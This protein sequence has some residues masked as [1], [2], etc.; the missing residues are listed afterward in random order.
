MIL[1]GTKKE[2]IDTMDKNT[3]FNQAVLH[4]PRWMDIRKRKETSEGGKF[5]K[6]IIGEIDD[7]QKEE[8]NYRGEFFLANYVG[9]EDKIID[10]L[11]Q[12]KVGD[13]HEGAVHLLDPDVSVVTT[14]E[15][16]YKGEETIA[17]HKEGMVF[18]KF[19]PNSKGEIKYTVNG[20]T[21]GAKVEKI[22][23]W[24]VFDEFALFS[25]LERYENEENKTLLKR[26]LM[27]FKRRPSSTAEGIANAIANGLI[28]Y[29]EI[30]PS[31]VEVS[32]AT[33]EDLLFADEEYGTVLERL[34]QVNRDVFRTKRWDESKWEHRFKELSYAP[35][36]WDCHP[37]L[38]QDGVGGDDA[39]KAS[40]LSDL[41]TGEGTNASIDLYEKSEAKVN[42]YIR[43]RRVE[44]DINLKLEKYSNV[45]VPKD[46]EYK[47]I[48]TPAVELGKDDIYIDCHQTS[49][50]EKD[51]YV[52]DLVLNKE[53]ISSSTVERGALKT[54]KKYKLRF[55]PKDTYGTMEIS[56]AVVSKNDGA[57]SLLGAKGAFGFGQDSIFKNMNVKLHTKDLADLSRFEN[58]KNSEKGLTLENAAKDGFGVIN[59]SDYSGQSVHIE[60]DIQDT[61]ITHNPSFVSLTGDLEISSENKI[62]STGQEGKIVIKTKCN[63]ISYGMSSGN[64]IVTK[65]INGVQSA[66]E[67]WFQPKSEKLEFTE[68]KD[69]T[70]VIQ[71]M[72]NS[73]PLVVENIRYARYTVDFEL[74]NRRLIRTPMGSVIPDLKGERENLIVTLRTHTGLS[75][76]VKFIHIGGNL[77]NAQYETDIFEGSAGA[78]LDVESNCEVVLETYDAN[79]V[80]EKTDRP[81]IS[82]DRYENKTSA[83]VYVEVDV[84]K[85][86]N[87][88]RTKPA[89]E[90]FSHQGRFSSWIKLL[91]GESLDTIRIDG[92]VKV[93]L[94]RVRINN[95]LKNN[96][97][98]EI[99]GAGK[100]KGF[101]VKRNE[102][103]EL[104]QI[105]RTDLATKADAYTIH[106]LPVGMRGAF[107]VDEKN[108]IESIGTSHNLSFE[109]F[110]IITT[111]Q[112]HIAYN[113]VRIIKQEISGVEIV[114]MFTPLVEPNKNMV[115]TIE[116]GDPNSKVTFMHEKSLQDWSLGKKPIHVFAGIN[117]TLNTNYQ[118]EML[119]LNKK[120]VLGNNMDLEDK[121]IIGAKEISLSEYIVTPPENMK[122]IHE[123]RSQDE[124]IFAQEDGFNKMAYANITQIK[125][126]RQENGEPISV[127][128]YELLSKEG[129]IAWKNPLLYGERI[130]I[131][132]TYG[133]P[134][135]L[136][137]TSLDQLYQV[138]GYSVDAYRFKETI[139]FKNIRE[140]FALKDAEAEK[141]KKADRL[142]SRSS[143]PN[144]DVRMD[145]TILR[146][147]KINEEDRVVVKSGYF[148]QDGQE[149]YHYNNR[150][151]NRLENLEDVELVDTDRSNGLLITDLSA[152]NLLPDSSM[153]PQRMTVVSILDA[154][155][156]S[157]DIGVG[158]AGRVGACDDFNGWRSLE[159]NLS[160]VDGIRAVA[161]KFSPIQPFGYAMM[162]ITSKVKKGDTISFY[163]SKGI[164]A[165]IAKGKPMSDSAKSTTKLAERGELMK[166]DQSFFL[167]EIKE[168][169]EG[170]MFLIV[171]GDGVVD[172][173]LIKPLTRETLENRHK[174]V[175]DKMGITIREKEPK[176]AIRSLYFDLSGNDVNGLEIDKEGVLRTASNV[177]WGITNIYE[178][179]QQWGNMSLKYARKIRDRYFVC[180]ED[181]GYVETEVIYLRALK[182]SR[183]LIVSINDWAADA[184]EG[185]DVSIYTSERF[186]GPF[187]LVH[188]EL[189][190]NKI[191]VS[192]TR[193]SDYFKIRVSGARG[194]VVSS[195]NAYAE[196]V[197]NDAKLRVNEAASGEV[198]SKVYDL[199]GE[200][201]AFMSSIK[202]DMVENPGTIVFSM[203]A[204]RDSGNDAVWTPWKEIALNR[205]LQAEGKV[206][207]DSFR[208]VQ[209]KIKMD[210]ASKIKIDQII[211]GVE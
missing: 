202:A 168:D 116:S 157:L 8:E 107:V 64:C 46:I 144:Y 19:P 5:L 146:L 122:I 37:D 15:E 189:G 206:Y 145:G 131:S 169:I 161:T 85:F 84:T 67:I 143:N 176:K 49:T 45:L 181:G 105:K 180:E 210:A 147:N 83:S 211:L 35:V 78:K 88:K 98:D 91:P 62:V 173:I 125:S 77:K 40:F 2:R 102:K 101:I 129:I 17:L 196:Y 152:T 26:C 185:L 73:V 27:A 123:G 128:D 165:Y 175:I 47:I 159:M 56:R 60:A 198:I 51:Y 199:G 82:K 149:L 30:D 79:N 38:I 194:K 109:T 204:R 121:Q 153:K 177:Q 142:I 155:K 61:S 117:H 171:Q 32:A 66:S 135:Y 44:A 50:G 36:P 187:N 200:E 192:S 92:D 33:E 208:Y 87:L 124:V 93:I 28:P 57:E 68:E 52:S 166:R 89:L 113:K 86:S 172:D 69:V 96:H 186:S 126:I 100:R 70:I 16:F 99:Y 108:N 156:D 197:E 190:T 22:H 31:E 53:E 164:S 6:A 24:N 132:Y 34:M 158:T 75:P 148:Y 179:R 140:D 94:N 118:S 120:V 71:K 9:K 3:A 163:A 104:I 136:V 193:L 174:T 54:G 90:K 154:R 162:D 55:L 23:I 201:T 151:E 207:F 160:F 112:E 106:N 59:V 141:I 48:A 188:T 130:T 74:E 97:S 81:Y 205:N 76:V 103:E 95:L 10:Y 138:V 137:F 150:S 43:N 63:R 39:L 41:E 119:E 203:R 184:M 7:I 191:A 20:Y 12:A 29:E 170:A 65:T 110:Y 18:F 115:Y 134:K 195:I 127:H 182:S 1:S 139:A 183:Q 209:Y 58:I 21:Y 178:S 133:A 4:F 25:G 42:D 14:V 11:Y 13:L 167:Y 80:L 114:D 72:N 111:P